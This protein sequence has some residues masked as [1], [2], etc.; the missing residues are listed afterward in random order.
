MRV[1]LK[2]RRLAYESERPAMVNYRGI[3]ITGQPVDLIIER[4]SL[5]S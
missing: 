2:A 4:V 1:E 3:E 5:S